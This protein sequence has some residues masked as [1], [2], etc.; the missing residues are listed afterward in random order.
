MMKRHHLSFLWTMKLLS[1][2]LRPRGFDRRV[3]QNLLAIVLDNIRWNRCLS[4]LGHYRCSFHMMLNYEGSCYI[5]PL[6]CFFL[7]TSWI[8]VK[9]LLSYGAMVLI[10]VWLGCLPTVGM[11]RKI[12][13]GLS[14][15]LLS[16]KNVERAVN[17]SLVKF[18][19]GC[20]F[21]MIGELSLWGHLSCKL[22]GRLG[23][24]V[25]AA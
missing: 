3:T 4:L 20:E 12:N 18:D 22:S 5:R 1:W 6:R 23:C 17:H 21:R 9:S 10:E 24:C 19:W 7:R 15:E 25:W 13:D 8:A 16:L 14:I 2:L 11:I